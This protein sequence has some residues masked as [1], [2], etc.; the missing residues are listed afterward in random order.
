MDPQDT[1]P[2]RANQILSQPLT[3]DKTAQVRTDP[4]LG[5]QIDDFVVDHVIGQGGMGK[6]YSARQI[7]LGRTV[8]L[9]VL[10]TDRELKTEAVIR[11]EAE[12][13]IAARLNHPNVVHIYAL[14]S[15]QGS[16]Y[17][18]MELVQGRNLGEILYER[19]AAGQGGLPMEQ[20]LS[21]MKQACQGLLAAFELGLVHRDIKPEN[22]LV[23]PK[24]HIKIADFGLARFLESGDQRLT[25]TGY[26]LGTPLYMS[27]EQVQ[28]LSVDSRSD[29]Y[30]LG[31]TFYHLLTGRPPFTAD[32]PFAVALKQ[33]HERPPSV[34]ILRTDC[35]TGISDLIDWMTEK[36]PAL[37][38]QS[39]E[40][41]IRSLQDFELGIGPKIPKSGGSTV[42][43]SSNQSFETVKGWDSRPPSVTVAS[44]RRKVILWL[45][46][47][48]AGSFVSLVFGRLKTRRSELANADSFKIWPPGLVMAQWNRVE[49]QGTAE[50]QYRFAQL[51]S[52]EQDQVAAW[53]SVPGYFPNDEDWSWRAYVQLTIDFVRKYD[54][55]HLVWLRDQMRDLS[56]GVPFENLKQAINAAIDSLDD[57]ETSC[58]ETL[59]SL[60]RETMDL[61]MAELVLTILLQYRLRIPR[62]QNVP[63]RLE[64]IQAQLLEILSIDPK[65]FPSNFSS[66]ISN[67]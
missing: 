58:F 20:C 37:R 62:G 67:R 23:N 51:Q 66:G 32:T 13:R 12:A 44:N 24:G 3:S 31:M 38:P 55:F 59:D 26:T 50:A 1:Q 4:W 47:T 48:L 28:G 17:L 10:S 63:I 46:F 21:I 5:R 49:K 34:R 7:S 8:A 65:M 53:L 56:R 40:V 14:G 6:V 41:V 29:L 16:P 2:I 64:K 9:K 42:T 11:F 60:V 35:P 45:G 19:A 27:P 22:L 57:R 25:Q 43:V 33:I 54:R 18:A 61:N 52:A 15:Y 30:S 39:V 36:T